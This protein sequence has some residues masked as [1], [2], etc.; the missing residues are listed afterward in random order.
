MLKLL[1]NNKLEPNKSSVTS[2]YNNYHSKK[3]TKIGQK[4]GGLYKGADGSITITLS[5][6]LCWEWSN[7]AGGNS[8]GK[9]PRPVGIRLLPGQVESRYGDNDN[10]LKTI[11]ASV[12]SLEDFIMS[13]DK[14]GKTKLEQLLKKKKIKNAMKEAEIDIGVKELSTASDKVVD[15]VGM[16]LLDLALRKDDNE[17]AKLVLNGALKKIV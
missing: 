3:S 8:G 13:S 5:S 6:D 4:G 7:S 11:F 17:L 10:A 15:G 9:N 16:K 2:M 14:L 12:E 1:K